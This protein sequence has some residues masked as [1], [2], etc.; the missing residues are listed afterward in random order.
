MLLGRGGPR[1][2]AQLSR[3]LKE[4]EKLI[5]GFAKDP[6]NAPPALI[7]RAL[8]ALSLVQNPELASLVQETLEESMNAGM[9]NQW[10]LEFVLLGCF[11]FAQSSPPA[12]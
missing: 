2:L 7:D 12:L 11:F 1:D 5:A 8:N 9:H 4:G 3:A 10:T 6:L